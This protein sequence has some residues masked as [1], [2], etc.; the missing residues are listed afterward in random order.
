MVGMMW[1]MPPRGLVAM[2]VR[3]ELNA[4][5]VKQVPSFVPGEPPN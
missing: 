2:E 4:L 5:N 3:S 1:R